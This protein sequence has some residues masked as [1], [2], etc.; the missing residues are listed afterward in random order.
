MFRTR[1]NY[2]AAAKVFTQWALPTEQLI[3]LFAEMYPQHY[4][5]DLTQMFP[6]LQ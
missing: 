6:E 5:D 1:L 4:V 3:L 2:W